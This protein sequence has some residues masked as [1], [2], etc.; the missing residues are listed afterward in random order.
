MDAIV[1]DLLL[2][3]HTLLDYQH[4]FDLTDEDLK[5]SFLTC[6][7]GFDTFNAEMTEQGRRVISCAR[8]YDLS[9]EEMAE[10]VQHNLNRMHDHLEEH[11]KAYRLDWPLRVIICDGMQR[12]DNPSKNKSVGF[13]PVSSS[14]RRFI[15]DASI[16][17]NFDRH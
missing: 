5:Q 7:S 9:P 3:G 6:A 15:R 10:L 8:N 12:E 11:Q 2:S 14:L 16:P 4:M 1:R 13:Y 17:P